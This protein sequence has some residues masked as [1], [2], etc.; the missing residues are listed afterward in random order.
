MWV[1]AEVTVCGSDG[2]GTVAWLAVNLADVT[3]F[4]CL[5]VL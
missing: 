3:R 4:D 5:V 2:S 1:E